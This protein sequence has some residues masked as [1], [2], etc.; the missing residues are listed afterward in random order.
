MCVTA[1]FFVDMIF[2]RLRSH[3]GLLYVCNCKFSIDIIFPR[4]RSH[5]GL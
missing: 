1:I 3:R 5:R 2:P 4:L